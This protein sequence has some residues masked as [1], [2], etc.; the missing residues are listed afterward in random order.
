MVPGRLAPMPLHDEVSGWI[1]QTV[2]REGAN[3]HMGFD[4]PVV[5]EQAGL[6]VEHVRAEAV[7]QGQNTLYAL[8]LAD[9]VR[10]ILPRIT[11][12]G[13]ASE[14]EIDIETLEQRLTTER[15]AANSIYVSDMAFGAWA[16]KP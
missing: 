3:I 11:K 4:L 15:I 1:S 9:I 8:P 2:K 7:I 5:L 13:V 12:Q 6:T 10:A 14:M 16:R